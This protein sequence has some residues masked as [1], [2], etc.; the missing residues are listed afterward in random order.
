[1]NVPDAT[2]PHTRALAALKRRGWKM[3]VFV[4][5]QPTNTQKPSKGPVENT[6]QDAGVRM[7]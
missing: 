4:L 3:T 1:M 5:K 2:V 7:E 6:A